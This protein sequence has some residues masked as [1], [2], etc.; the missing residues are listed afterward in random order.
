MI[1][2]Y[3]RFAVFITKSGT[4]SQLTHHNLNHSRSADVDVS[5]IFL[6]IRILSYNIHCI[7]Y[8]DNLQ[9]I[10]I[11]PLPCLFQRNCKLRH[12][13]STSPSY[14]SLIYSDFNNNSRQDIFITAPVMNPLQKGCNCVKE[15]HETT[16]LSGKITPNNEGKL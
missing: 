7:Y 5:E 16:F 10:L 12:T 2:H 4:K 9:T 15:R 8:T 1:F 3:C 6:N 11:I 13:V 14:L